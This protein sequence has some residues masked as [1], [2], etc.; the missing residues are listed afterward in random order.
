MDEMKNLYRKF[1][2]KLE[3]NRPGRTYYVEDTG[4]DWIQIFGK[5]HIAVL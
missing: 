1:L 3:E 5:Y 4:C 2:G